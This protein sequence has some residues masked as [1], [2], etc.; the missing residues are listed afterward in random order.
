[1]SLF[2]IVSAVLTFANSLYGLGAP[3]GNCKIYFQQL[4]NLL[5][6][7]SDSD[8]VKSIIKQIAKCKLSD[9]HHIFYSTF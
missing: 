4:L 1:M 2:H 9:P 6:V 7:Y 8:S 5:N 3:Q